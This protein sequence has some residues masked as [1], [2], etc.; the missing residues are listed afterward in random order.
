MSEKEYD[1][2]TAIATEICG[3]SMSV[4]S[5]IDEERQWF[6]SRVGIDV[7]ETH[8]D[9]AFCAHAI[10][11]PGEALI[12]EDARTD[13]R[14]QN[15]PLV[16]GNPH[17]VFYAG[18]PL[19]NDDVFA[20]GTLCVLDQK[21]KHLSD[22]Q[23]RALNA[24]S[25]QVMALLELRRS[26]MALEQSMLKLEQKNKDLEQF[27]FIAAHDLKSPLNGISTLTEL[28]LS[29]HCDA[30]REDGVRMMTAIKSSTSQLSGMIGGL[31]DYYRLDSSLDDK[32]ED[33]SIDDLKS[34]LDELYGGESRLV[35]DF[36]S[37]VQFLHVYRSALFQ[38]FVNLISNAIKYSDKEITHV[39]LR[40][41]ESSEYYL[42]EVS[43]NGPGIP[44]K[45]CDKLFQLF[46]VLAPHDRLGQKGNGIGLATV[47]K[48]VE[49]MGGEIAYVP[50]S[51]MGGKF[52]FSISK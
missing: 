10:H 23:I 47:K 49:R 12:V 20:L 39:S 37:D 46:S 43:D 4:I 26:K 9:F 18:I 32:R 33:L 22:S 25:D 24:L 1:Q 8:R 30:L 44:M 28:I 7:S 36:T 2:L 11:N 21:P 16:K 13:P 29:S 41:E 51:T 15:N 38:I 6:K 19:V 31:L 3:S 17:L 27:A 34:Q 5:L 45:D 40:I 48:L 50:G 14:F 42:F 35:I 52:R